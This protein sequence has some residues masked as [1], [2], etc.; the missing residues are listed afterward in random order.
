MPIVR[1]N[2]D[3]K[4]NPHRVFDI[5]FDQAKQ[6]HQAE[7]RYEEDFSRSNEPYV[8][9][10]QII[11][12]GAWIAHTD[13]IKSIQFIPITSEPLVMTASAD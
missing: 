3:K 12:K 10:S 11:Q 8:D 9:E 13:V 6:H 4:R 2:S 1:D 5:D 7:E